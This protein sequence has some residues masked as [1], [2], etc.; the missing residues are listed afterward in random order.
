[1]TTYAGPPI[2]SLLSILLLCLWIGTQVAHAATVNATSCSQTDVQNAVNSANN[3]DT[4]VVSG[5]C[6]IA[7]GSAV[8][9]PG[10]K[11]ITVNGGGN[12]TL[13]L[14]GFN[15]AQ[16]S[17]TSSRI[18]GFNF[19]SPGNG[20]GGAFA[21]KIGGSPTNAPYRIDHNKFTSSA[22]AV[23]VEVDGNGPGLIDHNSF[24]AGSGSEMIHN[25]GANPGGLACNMTGWSNDVVPGSSLM[26]FIEDN[27]YTNANPGYAYGA[28]AVQSYYGARTV[29]RHNTLYLTQIDQHGT[30]GAEW[31]RWWE[32]Y[33]NTFTTKSGDNQ[34]VYIVLRGGSGVAFNNAHTGPDAGY[35][36]LQMQDE[37]GQLCGRVGHGINDTSSPAYFWGNTDTNTS[38]G[39]MMVESDPGI[40]YFVSA[41]Q[42]STLTRCESAADVSAGCPVSY[43]Y[44]PYVYPYP[45]DANGLPSPSGSSSS[46]PGPQ[47]PAPPTNLSGTVH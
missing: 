19:T 4:V 7:W 44:K 39:K 30:A 23:Y 18:T 40:T 41:S 35:G 6:S 21:L 26:V 37:S 9:I 17:S 10:T 38:D 32:I 27:T 1:M 46:S 8:S 15:I 42:P 25:M 20:N 14:N 12:V 33:N 31:T 24:T 29:F 11:G 34:G 45:L 16:N 3:G 13:T 36:G 47:T 5:T 28:S 2:R 43:S 22:Q